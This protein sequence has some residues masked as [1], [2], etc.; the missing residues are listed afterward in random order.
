M[1]ELTFDEMDNVSGGNV[2]IDVAIRWGAVKLL[3]FIWDNKEAYIEALIHYTGQYG[4]MYDP[5][6]AMRQGS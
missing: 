1:R 3:D 4:G 6:T 2:L 5:Y